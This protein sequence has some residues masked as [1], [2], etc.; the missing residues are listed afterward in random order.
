LSEAGT[1]ADQKGD[2]R[3]GQNAHA[4]LH[5]FAPT[6]GHAGAVV[7]DAG[8]LVLDRVLPNSHQIA[9]TGDRST[10]RRH[11]ECSAIENEHELKR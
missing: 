10:D 7:S 4:S 9:A 5:F 8:W 11:L 3:R 6:P 1:A 2:R